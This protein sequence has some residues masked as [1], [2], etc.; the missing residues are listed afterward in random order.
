MISLFVSNV[1]M[2]SIVTVISI[3]GIYLV[4]EQRVELAAG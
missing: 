3:P 4:K 1:L 2:K